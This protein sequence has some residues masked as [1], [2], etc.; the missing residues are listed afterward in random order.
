[1]D[2]IRIFCSQTERYSKQS[3]GNPTASSK[4]VSTR[5]L[6]G[7][8]LKCI[9]IEPMTETQSIALASDRHQVS[10]GVAGTGKTFISL[11]K[12]FK[13][14]EEASKVYRKVVIIRSTVPTRDIGFLPGDENEKSA[15]YEEPYRDL[16]ST[17]FN[18]GDAYDILKNKGIVEFRPTS[19]L[20]GLTLD[21]AI[22]VV[23]ECQ[24]MTLHELD[25]II[26][27]VGLDC[28]IY[29]CGDFKQS[30]LS[31]NGMKPFTSILR[32]MDQFDIIE[33]GTQDIVRSDFVKSYIMARD[34][35]GL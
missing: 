28:K 27:R 3:I 34:R 19:F 25:T 31:V 23:D 2:V 14:M 16:V 6:A 11:F 33:Y 17:I 5:H 32:E 15:V 8:H 10:C 22:L 4:T 24:N 1:M 30:D 9:K 7:T 13:Q 35:L 26:T 12:A 20:R 29:F 18:R 21:N